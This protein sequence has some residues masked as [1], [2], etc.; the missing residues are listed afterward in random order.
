MTT[1]NAPSLETALTTFLAMLAGKNRSGGTIQAYGTDVAQFL[2]YLTETDV[3]VHS[4]ADITKSHLTEYMTYL[5]RERALSGVSCARKLA[6]IREYFR[7]L[8]D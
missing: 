1:T 4:P 2:A 7:F 5:S 6:A 3:T 8:V